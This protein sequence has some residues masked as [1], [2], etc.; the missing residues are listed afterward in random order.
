[1]ES[2]IETMYHAKHQGKL[3]M[4][5]RPKLKKNKDIVQVYIILFWI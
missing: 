2:K 1:M 3:L 5:Q 4:R